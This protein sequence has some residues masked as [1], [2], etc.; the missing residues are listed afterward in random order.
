M[1]RKDDNEDKEKVIVEVRID[2][3]DSGKRSPQLS[4]RSPAILT[5]A[6]VIE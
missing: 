6:V 1:R 3:T 2:G 5:E 4:P